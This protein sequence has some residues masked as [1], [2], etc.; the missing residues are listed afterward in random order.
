MQRL[1]AYIEDRIHTPGLIGILANPF[2]IARRGLYNS[3]RGLAPE[4]TGNLLDIGCGKKPYL[5][6][7]VNVSSYIG[8]ELDTPENRRR[9]LADVYYDGEK[10]PYPDDSF[11]NVLC[12]QVLE[13]VFEVGDLLHEISR[14]L[15]PGGTLLLTVPF[16]WDEHEQPIDFARYSSFGLRYIIEKSGLSIKTHEKI[17]NDFG[18]L[19][20]LFNTY[21]YKATRS[22]LP[23][24]R[25]LWTIF[26]MS[27]ST[28][29]GLVTSRI[30]P[31][32]DD[33]YL[34]N[35]MLAR[36]DKHP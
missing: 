22:H 2:Y 1:T 15:K 26:I 5:P 24:F 36:K 3:I 12:N 32:N 17:N 13:H 11:D 10:L 14:V 33:L 21:V 23:F 29:I 31:S 20:Q 16:V 7:F 35:V 34:D 6:L 30:L 27:P 19:F 18:L 28:A 4:L 25:A 8:L 9:N